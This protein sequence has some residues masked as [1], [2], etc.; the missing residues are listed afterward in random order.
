MGETRS[1]SPVELEGMPVTK[2]KCGSDCALELQESYSN[3]HISHL[4]RR[5]GTCFHAALGHINQ[6]R[7][8]RSK[9]NKNCISILVLERTGEGVRTDLTFTLLMSTTTYLN[10]QRQFVLPSGHCKLKVCSQVDPSRACGGPDRPPI[11]LAESS[12]GT[13]HSWNQ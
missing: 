7:L 2:S 4:T 1:Y 8:R 10:I 9:S 11:F 13:A 5:L 6:K 3:G 12:N